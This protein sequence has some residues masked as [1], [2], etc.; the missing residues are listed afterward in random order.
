MGARRSHMAMQ[1]PPMSKRWMLPA[2]AIALV[3]SL[4]LNLWLARELRD[5]FVALQL[6]RLFPLGYTRDPQRPD[7]AGTPESVVFYGD[8]RASTWSEAGLTAQR[9]SENRAHGA[10]TASQTLLQLQS[11]PA[12][13]SGVAVVQ[14]GI[15]D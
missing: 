12:V 9:R 5:G 13:H 7:V 14:V 1:R 10:Q 8:S 15:N 4:A 2:V 3:A 6:A 11:A